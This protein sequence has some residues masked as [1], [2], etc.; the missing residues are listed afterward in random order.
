MKPRNPPCTGLLFWNRYYNPSPMRGAALPFTVRNE[1]RSRSVGL[2]EELRGSFIVGFEN[3]L[4]IRCWFARPREV[5][6]KEK[7]FGSS[8]N[9]SPN[10]WR[11]RRSV[12]LFD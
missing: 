1:L 5:F 10:F 6:G 8:D 7:R 2:I 4:H 3:D 11:Q 12:S 9:V